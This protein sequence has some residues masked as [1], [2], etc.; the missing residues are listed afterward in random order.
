MSKKITVQI[1]DAISTLFLKTNRNAI[2]PFILP[3]NYVEINSLRSYVFL[4]HNVRRRM[5]FHVIT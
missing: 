4:M 3:K 1:N 5:Q 2:L